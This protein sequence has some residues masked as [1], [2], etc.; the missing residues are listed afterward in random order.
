MKKEV[1]KVSEKTLQKK[2]IDYL[3]S[4]GAVVVKVNN[5]A[6]YNPYRKS[7]IPPRRKG[8][9]DILCCYKGYFI[10]IEVKGTGSYATKEQKEFIEQV[11]INGGFGITTRK[12]EEVVELI[13]T[14]SA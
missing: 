2:I 14:L 1:K 5:G 11:K 6:V 4:I 7:W 10:A 13:D 9:S 8:V 12:F 3:E